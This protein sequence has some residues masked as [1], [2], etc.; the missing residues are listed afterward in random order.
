MMVE[1]VS[2]DPAEVQRYKAGDKKLMGFFV[3][4]AMKATKGAGNPKEINAI[5][6]KMLE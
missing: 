4:Q 5:V 3:G 1:S 2:M 6:T